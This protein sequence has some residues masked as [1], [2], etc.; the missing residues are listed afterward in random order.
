M[1]ILMVSR[2]V[3]KVQFAR[4]LTHVPEEEGEKRSRM[5]AGWQSAVSRCFESGVV[6]RS[7]RGG[8]DCMGHEFLKQS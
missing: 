5:R 2:G 4:S 8:Q 6:R 7:S 1:K 3:T